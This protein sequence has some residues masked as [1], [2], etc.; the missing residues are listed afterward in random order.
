MFRS[1]P[2]SLAS[3]C[4]SQRTQSVTV[5]NTYNINVCRSLHAK[6]QLFV[7]DFNQHWICWTDF[8][9]NFQYKILLKSLQWEPSSTETFWQVCINKVQECACW[10]CHFCVCVCVLQLKYWTDFYEILYCGVLLKFVDTL[11]VWLEGDNSRR[12]FI[13]CECNLV[14]V[15]YRE[16]CFAMLE[17]LHCVFVSGLVY[18]DNWYLIVSYIMLTHVWANITLGVY[19]ALISCS[20]CISLM[21]M[22]NWWFL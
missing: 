8:S 11:Q 6:C 20:I 17:F 7:F 19:R 21:M 1:S 4:T 13:H 18:L 3:A 15:H 10:L 22:I 9:K 5:T 2:V 12:H 14:N 16:K